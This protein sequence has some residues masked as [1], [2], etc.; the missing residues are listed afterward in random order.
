MCKTAVL[1]V[2]SPLLT[3]HFIPNSCNVT[4][5]R[6]NFV[7]EVLVLKVKRI[8]VDAE[9]NFSVYNLIYYSGVIRTG[10]C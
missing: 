10:Q 4:T 5:V 1:V 6:S 3:V 9:I 7:L 8:K 2:H